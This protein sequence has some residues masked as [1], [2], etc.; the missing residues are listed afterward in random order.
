GVGIGRTPTLR[1]AERD[2]DESAL[3]RHPHR[4]CTDVVEI[5]RGV[6]A[7]PA[8]RRSARHVVLDPVAG[9]YLDRTVVELDGGVPGPLR[10][11]AARDRAKL[12]CE[13]QMVGSEVELGERGGE[14]SRTTRRDRRLGRERKLLHRG[15]GSLASRTGHTPG[16]YRCSAT[17]KYS[18]R[19]THERSV[20][21]PRTCSRPLAPP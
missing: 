9:E 7:E 4:E 17:N 12:R 21:R 19:E 10:R 15:W 2:I 6:V 20:K 16:R 14:S 8:L 5:R 3:P 11:R 18:E 13:L 1:A